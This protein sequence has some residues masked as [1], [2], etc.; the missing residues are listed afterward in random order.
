M[1]EQ[2]LA[3]WKPRLPDRVDKISRDLYV[4]DLI[5]GDATVTLAGELKRDGISIFE[6]ASFEL[7]K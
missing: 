6:D 5:S 3:A 2:H 7:H 1:I 4:D